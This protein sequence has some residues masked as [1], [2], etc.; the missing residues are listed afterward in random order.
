MTVE[1]HLLDGHYD[2]LPSL[3]ADLVRRRVAVFATPGG[4]PTS[5]AAKAASTTIPSVFGVGTDPVKLGLVASLARSSGN[6]TGVNFFTQEITAKRLAL[7]HELAPKAVV[8]LARR[9][10]T[11]E[12]RGHGY[13]HPIVE[14]GSYAASLRVISAKAARPSS[15][16]EYGA[17]NSELV[18]STKCFRLRYCMSAF[19][20]W[21][22]I[23]SISVTSR[24]RSAPESKIVESTFRTRS[25]STGR[26]G[27]AARR[28]D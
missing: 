13:A 8:R 25:D 17:S 26:R 20:D 1:Y 3:M 12:E 11:K 14:D 21:R 7:L 6:A 5:Q 10:K 24:M 23:L 15:V 22:G 27:S 16:N 4:N 28:A 9:E 2:R 19:I 18:F